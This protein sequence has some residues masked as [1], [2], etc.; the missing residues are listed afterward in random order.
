MWDK[1]REG[2]RC[3]CTNEPVWHLYSVPL[4]TLGNCAEQTSELSHLGTKEPR[5]CIHL[6]PSFVKGWSWGC[7]SSTHDTFHLPFV[8]VERAPSC[9][10]EN[11]WQRGEGTCS[12]KPLSNT[13]ILS[14]KEYGQ[15]LDSVLFGDSGQ[16]MVLLHVQILSSSPFFLETLSWRQWVSIPSLGKAA[17]FPSLGREV[18]FVF[19]HLVPYSII[20]PAFLNP[21]LLWEASYPVISALVSLTQGVYSSIMPHI[22]TSTY[23]TSTPARMSFLI[24]RRVCPPETFTSTSLQPSVPLDTLHCII[25]K[26]CSP[27]TYK[28][29]CFPPTN[30]YLSALFLSHSLDLIFDPSETHNTLNLFT[31]HT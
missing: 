30:S 10:K 20:R 11:P 16:V 22:L 14:T 21:L 17:H 2:N 6:L 12:R 13:R 23:A 24:P 8:R 1:P 29:T 3:V 18:R 27:T 5:A 4:G 19:I 15:N 26:N 31:R 28:F 9:I 25:I 7:K